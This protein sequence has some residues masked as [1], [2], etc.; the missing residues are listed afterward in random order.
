M[1]YALKEF[2]HRVGG[3]LSSTES[4]GNYQIAE[5]ILKYF[6]KVIQK[7]KIAKKE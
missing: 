2:N 3:H 6:Q 7:R 4:F 5:A 1:N